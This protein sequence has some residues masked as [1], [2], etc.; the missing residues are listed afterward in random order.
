MSTGSRRPKSLSF[1][2][3][4]SF[5][6]ALLFALTPA[7]AATG[8]IMLHVGEAGFIIGVSGGQGQLDFGGRVYPLS[9]GGVSIGLTI[10]ASAQNLTGDVLNINNPADIQGTYSQIS[11]SA[12]FGPGGKVI[13][14]QNDRG[15]VLNLQ[16]FEVGFEASVDLG[17][18]TIS[19]K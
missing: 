5:A 19:L 2:A 10:G 14:M 16:G 6:L 11:A 7:Q 13:Q 12:S 15:V 1:A 4:V 3:V 17:G 18:L 8:R 9:V